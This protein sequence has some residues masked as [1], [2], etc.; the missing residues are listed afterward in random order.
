MGA[1]GPLNFNYC[2]SSVKTNKKVFKTSTENCKMISAH[3]YSSTF[4]CIKLGGGSKKSLEGSLSSDTLKCG[5]T[6]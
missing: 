1:G 2:H 4:T 6:K 5:N 3:P